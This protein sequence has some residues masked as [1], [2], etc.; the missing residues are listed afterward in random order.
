[1]TKEEKLELAKNFYDKLNLENTT[2]EI[3]RDDEI[4]ADYVWIPDM[5]GPGGLII[6]DNGELLFC[7]SAKGFD[8]WKEEYKK[9]MRSSEIDEKS[10]SVFT[11]YV[12]MEFDE[13]KNLIKEKTTLLQSKLSGNIDEKEKSNE[14]YLF[15]NCKMILRNICMASEKLI[16]KFKDELSNE[17]YN[18]FA[19]KCEIIKADEKGWIDMKS[20]ESTFKKAF[21]VETEKDSIK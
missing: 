9:G 12:G 13:I 6:G 21:N 17:E 18:D 1:M 11:S 15:W 3:K 7:Q 4:L 5:R 8:F 14:G 20:I 19:K 2:F 10:E 16:N